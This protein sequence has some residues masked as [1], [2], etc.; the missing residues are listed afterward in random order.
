MDDQ[1]V[2]QPVVAGVD[3]SESSL[4]A[5]RWAAREADQRRAPLRLVAAVGWVDVPHQ[6][7]DP[8]TGPDLRKV[9][10]SQARTHLADAARAA[11]DAV[12][13][14]EPEQEVLDG[15]PI[16]QLVAESRRAQLVVIGDRGLGGVAGLLIGS[17]A[18]ALAAEGSC[19]VVV[20]RGQADTTSGPVVVGVDGSPISEA[21]LAY[22]FEAA[23]LRGAPLLAVH[24]WRDV[25]LLAVHAERDVPLDPMTW[26][27]LDWDAVERQAQADLAER[28]AGWREKY[29]DVDVQRLVAQDRPAKV[30]VEQS[31]GAQLVVVG[32]R[33]RG[34]LA[35]LLLG[36]VSHA[37]LHRAE[38]PV[39]IVRTDVG[40][41]AR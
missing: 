22:A 3:G 2:G 30:L 25:P 23:A 14:Q 8:R 12:P 40:A 10:L 15:F 5:V 19:P 26:A 29:P 16:P 18:F 38:C 1:R 35:G 36:S 20:V 17:V 9:L 37:V 7:G 27:S 33:G 41:A 4:Q 21:A 6:Y 39:A 13:G 31:A 11:V 34:G 32:S 24:A 28:L